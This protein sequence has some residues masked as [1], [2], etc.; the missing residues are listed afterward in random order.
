M[1]P[2]QLKYLN[3]SRKAKRAITL[4]ILTTMLI[5]NGH[6]QKVEQFIEQAKEYNPGLKALRLEY[7]AALLKAD[8]VNDW[9]DPKVSLGLGVLP[10]E[11][12]LGAQRFKVGV[13]QMIPWKGSL[14][15]RSD[16]ARSKAEVKSKL[17][18][19]KEIDIEYA[20]RSA[21]TTLQFLDGK[22]AI[23]QQRLFVLDALEE[24]AK[25][26]VRSGKGKLSNVLFTERKREIL[27]ADLELITKKMEQ[28]TIM[29]NRWT[30]R[31]LFTEIIIT[32]DDETLINKSE[33]LKFADSEHPKYTVLDNKIAASN[34]MIALTK[35]QEKPKIGVGLDYA[36]IDARNDVDISGNGRDILM[37]MVSITIP[38]NKGRFDAIRQEQ[39]ILQ[40][41]INA[42]RKEISDIYTA[43]VE[44][45]YSLIEYA[46]QVAEKYSSLKDITRE[47]LKLMR[48]EYA[49][50]G[51]RF[52]ELLRLE[53]DIIDYDL[54]ILKARFERSLALAVLHK[55]N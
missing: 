3:I 35:Y 49:T 18:E 9:P 10:V 2:A 48:T 14:D 28:P 16:V 4:C 23:I 8:Q 22:K 6:S 33:V 15:A 44:M 54:E 34:S 11:T 31:E 27:N 50:E 12:R 32:T 26:A 29:I 45:A 13:S 52:E 36:Y 40:E 19:V 46:N 24:L 21:Y 37:P 47:T 41:A 55:F 43:E 53:M 17:D 39:T 7:N 42:Q 20:I 5:Y 1:I 38:L 25:S 30:G 51:T